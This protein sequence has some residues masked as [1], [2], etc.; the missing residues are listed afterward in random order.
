MNLKTSSRAQAADAQGTPP[1]AP[2]ST[3]LM[4]LVPFVL[5]LAI[6]SYFILRY[7]GAWS[8]SDSALFSLYI[9]PVAHTGRL[10]AADA[11]G[12]GAYPNGFAF[13]AVSTYILG[14]TRLSV[15]TLQQV[16]YPLLAAFVVLPAW[17]LY[18]ELV[19][20]AWGAAIATS[21]LFAQPEFLFVILRSS[22][23]KFTRS[24]LLL[25]L[26]WLVRV[27]K[28]RDRPYLSAS[29]GILFYV[30]A[31]SMIASNNLIGQSFTMALLLSLLLGASI[32][33]YR[34][35]IGSNPARVLQRASYWVITLLILGFFFTYYAY[36]PA[37]TDISLLKN[38]L[39]QIAVLLFDFSHSGA[40]TGAYT[41]VSGAWI[42]L[43]VYF[44]V[45]A[46]DWIILVLSFSLWVR[47]GWIWIVKGYAPKRD[48][49]W[50][51]WLFYASFAIQGLVSAVAD[52][53]GSIG[54]LQERVFPSVS[55]F[56]V[57]LVAAAWTDMRV[58]SAALVRRP[59]QALGACTLLGLTVLSTFKAT[60]EPVVSNK[61]I[62]YVHP[63]VSA[64]VWAV[65]RLS[66]EEIWA[67]FDERLA[68]A[69]ETVE[70]DWVNG[71]RISGFVL[72]PFMRTLVVSDVI[73]QQSLRLGVALPLPPDALRIYDNGEA[74]VYRLRPQNPF[75]K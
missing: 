58:P 74:Q 22:H 3:W 66:G 56:G 5:V 30:A 43:P 23:E 68:T 33:K 60:A 73:R 65:H 53:S 45:S 59:V 35:H 25:C 51:L 72:R 24:L 19:G 27:L 57:A 1:T 40:T 4:L 17:L 13:Q 64:M 49:A 10:I 31:F 46:A 36:P 32:A 50:Y 11:N 20:S 71:N 9:R 12:T 8:E 28:V 37:V 52:I 61:W 16:V 14:V 48:A 41:Q 38:V 6:G 55:I 2:D 26:Y 67:G 62:F 54:N 47:Q 63:E 29:Y 69:F 75:Q 70:G 7:G 21:L 44:T 42:N 34:P 39:S 15:T 18:R